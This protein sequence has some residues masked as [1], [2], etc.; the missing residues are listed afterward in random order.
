MAW[1]NETN[2]EKLNFMVAGNHYSGYGLLQSSLAAHP[3]IIC[4]GDVLHKN[5]SVRRQAHAA[6]FGPAGK[7]A[8]HFVPTHLSLEQYLNNKIFDNTLYSEKAV[9]VKIDYQNMIQYDLWEYLDQKHR[10]G[11]FCVVHVLRN[12]V[13]CYVSMKQREG[14]NGLNAQAAVNV[15]VHIDS[16][17]MTLFVR[18][19]V[20]AM[21]KINRLCPDR[22]VVSY[23]ELLLNFRSVL[24]K[25]FKFLELDFSP[26]CIPNQRRVYRKEIRNRVSNWSQLQDTLPPDVREFL[27][28]P[29]LF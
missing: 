7:V 11:D 22:A 17:A 26:A 24:E 9:G 14:L 25:V 1:Y 29:S 21:L 23:H 19:H 20:A 2:P 5:D 27:D 18:D 28:C 13:A 8:D 3:Q 15:P 16:D 6:Y 10:C 12:P 4:H